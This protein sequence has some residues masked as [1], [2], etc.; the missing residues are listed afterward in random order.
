[1][2]ITVG[3]AHGHH[4]AA[5]FRNLLGSVNGHVTAAGDHHRLAGNRLAVGFQHGMDKVAKAKAGGFLPGKG[6]APGEPLAGQHAFIQA[7]DPLILAVQEA[8]FPG[9][10]ADVSGRHVHVLAHM[11]VQLGHKALAETLHF[12]VALALG[13]KVAAALAAAD[14]QSGQAVL[15][16]LLQTEKL[17]DGQVDTGMQA[18]AAL[19]RANGTVKLDTI[20]PVDLNLTLVVHPWYTEHDDPFRL[21]VPFQQSGLLVFWMT[22]HHRLQGGQ[23]LR[24]GLNKFGLMGVAGFQII[25]YSLCVVAHMQFSFLISARVGCPLR[26]FGFVDKASVLLHSTWYAVDIAIGRLPFLC[27]SCNETSCSSP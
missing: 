19:V 6:T 21:H 12:V 5:H 16:N 26:C 14:G 9:T 27:F 11:A 18:Q 3:V 7:G 24:G 17:N 23:D 13:V 4:L 15:Q 10:H 25:Q 8:D 2:N 20:A 22:I 1:M